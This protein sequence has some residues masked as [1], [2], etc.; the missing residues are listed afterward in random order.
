M[1][2]T[3]VLILSL[4]CSICPVRI[5]LSSALDGRTV[6]GLVSRPSAGTRRYSVCL[7]QDCLL[8]RLTRQDE[9]RSDELTIHLACPITVV[10]WPVITL[11]IK[12]RPSPFYS[13]MTLRRPSRD[14]A[15]RSLCSTVKQHGLCFPLSIIERLRWTVM[16][17]PRRGIRGG[18][19]RRAASVIN[20]AVW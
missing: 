10:R 15:A 19:H 1:L 16:D 4:P 14:A 2:R 11:S 5:P 6:S 9:P 18:Q 8:A 13:A 7:V 20:G 12:F 3:H 17:Q